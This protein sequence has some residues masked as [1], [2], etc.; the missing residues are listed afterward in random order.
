MSNNY[1]LKTGPGSALPPELNLHI[2]R[3]AH[4][5]AF[6]FQAYDFRGKPAFAL[7]TQLNDKGHAEI[8]CTMSFPAVPAFK[9]SSWAEWKMHLLSPGNKLEDEGGKLQDIPTFIA[10]I[11]KNGHPERG[12]FGPGNTPVKG[13]VSVALTGPGA[14]PESYKARNWLDA[15]GY[16]FSLENFS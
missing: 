14:V 15:E 10:Y 5:W 9:I 1:Y 7:P 8:Y 12:T 6:L 16:E 13:D 11:E 3:S 2:G 4:G